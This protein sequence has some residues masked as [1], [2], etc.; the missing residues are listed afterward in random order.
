MTYIPGL[1]TSFIF[2]NFNGTSGDVDVLTHE[3]GHSLQGF[4]GGDNIP[5]YRNPGMECCEM[6]SMSME[7]LTYPWMK[8][9]FKEDTE[10]YLYQHLFYI[11]NHQYLY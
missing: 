11:L 8:Y 6:H 10:K 7:Y 9:F 1:K 5:A 4:L 2:S 3:F